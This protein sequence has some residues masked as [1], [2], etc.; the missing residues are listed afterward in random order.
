MPECS[1]SIS[2]DLQRTFI[3]EN[4]HVPK[5]SLIRF[6]SFELNGLWLNHLRLSFPALRA[7]KGIDALRKSRKNRDSRKLKAR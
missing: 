1:F 2:G 7:V 3:F 6:V 4:R 5:L